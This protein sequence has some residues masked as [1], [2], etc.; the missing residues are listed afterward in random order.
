MSNFTSLKINLLIPELSLFAVIVFYL[1]AVL[2]IDDS[3]Q[4]KIDVLLIVSLIFLGIFQLFNVGDISSQKAMNEMYVQDSLSNLLKGISTLLLSLLFIYSFKNTETIGVTK[5]EFHLLS[6]F[7][8]LGQFIIIS[9]SHLITIYLGIELLS[10][11]LVSAV[12]LRRDSGNSSEAAMKYFVLAAL[13]SGFMLYG[14]SMLYGVTGSLELVS[15]SNQIVYE[16]D[17]IV[18]I[19][20]LV[21][22]L[23]G[24]GFKFGAVP[25]HMW[26]PDVYQGSSFSTCMLIGAAPKLAAI[27]L[28]LRLL[29]EGLPQLSQDWE[30]IFLLMGLFS[31]ILGNFVA[32]AQKNLKRMLGYSTIGHVG[33]IFL[34]FG[35][36]IL[37]QNSVSAISAYSAAVFYVAIYSMTVTGVFGALLLINKGKDDMEE[38]DHLKGLMKENPLVSWCLVA[39]MFSMAGVPPAIGFYAKFVVLESLISS[40]YFSLVVLAALSSVVGAFYY[41]RIIKVIVF[42][43][44]QENDVF[45][46][47]SNIALVPKLLLT[48]NGVSI[49]VLGLF[50]SQIM[51]LFQY[52]IKNSL[53]F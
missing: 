52:A 2:F 10:L 43:D 35:S 19:F 20:G 7:A 24:I 5:S 12:A 6:L 1:L 18:L 29:V 40:N 15:I 42:D 30:K 38:I 45:F 31:V 21:F 50:P 46:K 4:K 39:F 41:L 26:V 44:T 27:A 36:S 22:L 53:S 14:M 17:N 47:E 8:L 49:V 16:N 51:N 33:F 48:L 37:Q 3:N 32:I 28:L 13:A 23:A 34:A 11:S 25:F 9:A